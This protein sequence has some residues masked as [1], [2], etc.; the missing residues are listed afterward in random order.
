MNVGAASARGDVLL[1]LHADTQL[2]E[3]AAGHL[4]EFFQSSR[5]WGRFDVRLSGERRLFRMIAWFMNRRSRLTGIATGDQAMFVRGRLFRQ[6]GGF[7]A[8]EILE[9]VTFSERLVE[10]TEPV[11]MEQSVTTDARKFIRMGIWRSI[12]RVIAIMLCH[13]L[14]L[15]IL[16]MRF[17]QDIR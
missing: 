2:P 8:G 9:D 6:I 12:G 13:E 14:R 3:G 10:A 4:A 16:P 15:P 7:P 1:F 5:Q 17:F 11:L